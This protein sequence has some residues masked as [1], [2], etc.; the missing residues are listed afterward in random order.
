[1]SGIS[2]FHITFNV[3]TTLLLLPFTRLLEKL[4]VLTIRDKKSVQGG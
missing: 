4:A 1:M 3:L 2:Y